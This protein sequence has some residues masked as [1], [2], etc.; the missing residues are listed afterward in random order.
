MARANLSDTGQ[1]A[2]IGLASPQAAGALRSTVPG[3]ERIDWR[4]T[5]VEPVFCDLLTTLRPVAPIAGA[6]PHGLGIALADGAT[7]LTDG[8]RIMPHVTMA[9]FAGDLRVDYVGHDGSVVHLYPTLAEP[10][11]NVAA[12][13]ARHLAAGTPLALGD[14][15]P[16]RPVWEVGPPYGTDMIVAV[17]SSVA[18]PVSPAQNAEDNGAEYLRDLRSA[19]AKARQDG[20]EVT[21]TIMPVD[22]LPKAKP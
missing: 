11:R 1:V 12:Q 7:S 3:G 2:V 18:L 15:G 19:I 8:S 6:P 17:A 5:A 9:D 14:P 21:A 16:G 22:T 13:K 20:A 4:V 10:A